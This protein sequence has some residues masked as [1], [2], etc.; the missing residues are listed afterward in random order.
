[1][2]KSQ[3][4]SGGKKPSRDFDRAKKQDGNPRISTCP[5]SHDCK[6]PV[7]NLLGEIARV[8]LSLLTSSRGAFKL[9]QWCWRSAAVAENAIAYAKQRKASSKWIA[10]RLVREKLANMATLIYVGEAL[11]IAPEA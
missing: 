10:D 8:T 2:E 1:M 7:E 3:R 5:V 11:S 9:V 4:V 6:V